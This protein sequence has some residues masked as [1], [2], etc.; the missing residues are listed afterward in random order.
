MRDRI[1]ELKRRVQG[2]EYSA[3]ARANA[4]RT[5]A[6]FLHPEVAELYAKILSEPEE[7]SV[8]LDTLKILGFSMIEE[9]KTYLALGIQIRR[10]VETAQEDM[11]LVYALKAAANFTDV[12]KMLPTVLT[13]LFNKEADIDARLYAFESIKEAGDSEQ[14]RVVLE[15][16]LSDPEFSK[17]A[18]ALLKKWE[19]DVRDKKTKGEDRRVRD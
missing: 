2:E 10:L 12:P 4:V 18:S 3:D 15:N 8:V 7:P 14:T 6:T 1:K 9:E 5:L 17:D 16:L 19:K 13:V 11:V